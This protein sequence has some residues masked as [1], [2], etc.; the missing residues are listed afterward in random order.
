[1][2]KRHGSF[3]QAQNSAAALQA[4]FQQGLMLH[5]QGK[6]ADAE[7][8][9]HEVLQ[10]QPSHFDALHLLGYIALQT[11]RAE[12]AVELVGKAIRLNSNVAAAHS[13]LGVALMGLKRSEEAVASFDR[14]IALKAEYAE[15]FYNRGIALMD[16]KRPEEA[17][18]SYDRAIA[19]KPDYA[20]AFSNRGNALKDLKRPEEAVASYDRAIALKP[21]YP[22]AYSNR[23]NALKDLKRLEEAVAS[24]DKAIA[25]KPD[26]VDAYSN[27]GNA[28][29]DLKRPQEAVASYDR[30]IAFS[31]DCAE[32]YSNRGNALMDLKRPEA[33]VASYD[34]AIAL[35]PNYAEAYSNRGNALLG[36]KRAEEAVESY[37]KAIALK[38]D[39]AEAYYNRGNG[40]KDLKRPEEALASYEKAIALEPDYVEAYSN[41]G[42]ALMELMRAEEA[43]ASNDRAIAL[44]P[45]CAEAYSNRGNALMDLMRPEEAVASFNRAIA[46]KPG[47]A[48][49]HSNR[50]N[51]LLGLM[52]AEEAVAS[53]DSAI[54]LKPDC[55][56]AYFN[57][58]FVSLLRGEFA[59]GWHDYEWRKRKEEPHGNRIVAKPLWLGE[60]DLAGKSLFI[61]WEQGLGDTIQFCRYA[62]LASAHG[63]RVVLSV[64]DA[65]VG[66]LK[67]LEPEITIIG[68]NQQ[69]SDFDL[70]CPLLSM[71]LAFKT[72]LQN[73]PN[74]VPYLQAE[75]DRIARWAKKLGP[76]GF[77]IGICWHGS[78]T[79]YGMARSF[80]IT[81][82][83]GISKFEN[84]RLISLHRGSGEQQLQNLP[85]GMRV[86]ILGAEFDAGQDAFMDTAAVMKCC[87]LIITCDT[88]IEHVAGALGVPVWV[89]LQRVPDWRWM[90]D[91][92]DSPWYPTMRL[93]RQKVRN[94]WKS[95][96]LEIEKELSAVLLERQRKNDPVA[97]PCLPISWGEVIDKITILEIKSVKLL[98]E[99]ALANVKN[100]L[101][102]L[103][104]AAAPHLL[105]NA[106]LAQLKDRLTV[107]NEALWV[108]EDNIREKEAKQEFDSQFIELARSV[109]K[110]NDAR[111]GIKRE[112]NI[113]MA[114]ELI[115]EKSYSK[116]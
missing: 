15:A 107:V 2:S 65:L 32:A 69:P 98:D 13:I 47:Y 8:I 31:P 71:P 115:E 12:R 76:D 50:G 19:L 110:Q 79:K 5:R 56:D 81:E 100:E 7:R 63:A 74:K 80:P 34:R 52:R 48:E 87:D 1:M 21:D 24:Y 89:A 66:L 26:Y 45:D 95:V 42:N 62:L 78:A 106:E 51:A 20:E 104:V 114:S 99:R 60:E 59:S 49:A 88:A 6:L 53:Y 92:A 82:F 61:H 38:P 111:A 10:R 105:S 97:T 55:A 18:A 84:V 93:F 67:P 96:F 54:A 11:R 23:G 58:S 90:L 36:L 86:E 57:K 43:V 113:T 68:N 44:K 25:C 40:L 3:R 4:K 30:A 102:I 70:H 27:R 101:S 83:I 39:L 35:K 75:P 17:V 77:K 108:I 85:D 14:A 109:Y 46:F 72:T 91:R 41:R 9:C 94:D 28:L 64:Q 73:I 16:L 112:I 33:A 103:S 22:E 116:Y 29:K 37:D